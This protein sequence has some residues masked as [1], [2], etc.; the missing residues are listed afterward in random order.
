MKTTT[1]NLYSLSELSEESQKR[2]LSDLSDINIQ[3]EWWDFMYED[4]KRMGLQITAFDLSYRQSISGEI[5]STHEHV[6]SSILNEYAIGS[7]I[8]TI[9]KT[10]IDI[11]NSLRDNEAKL[12][13]RL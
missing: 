10:F 5:L 4:A 12:N 8:W 11:L 7:P 3:D 6:A 13:A 1:V 9:A 2:A